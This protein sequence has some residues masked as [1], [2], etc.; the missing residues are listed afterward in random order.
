MCCMSDKLYNFIINKEKIW[1]IFDWLQCGN[2]ITYANHIKYLFENGG[3][4]EINI[5]I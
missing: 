5:F 4:Y 3:I 2:A 1:F